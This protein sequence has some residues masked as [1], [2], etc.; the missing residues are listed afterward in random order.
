M[1]KRLQESARYYLN[2]TA[3][4]HPRP[5]ESVIN[6]LYPNLTEDDLQ[7]YDFK[8]SFFRIIDIMKEEQHP[9]A[10]LFDGYAEA[11]IFGGFS[12]VDAQLKGIYLHTMVEILANNP[13]NRFPTFEEFCKPQ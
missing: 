10:E 3:G 13:S 8:S 9:D 6:Q 12:G 7:A 1:S 2:V 4:M 5:N 11:E